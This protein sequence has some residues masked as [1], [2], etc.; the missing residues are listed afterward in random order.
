MANVNDKAAHAAPLARESAAGRT[1]CA[2]ALGD[3]QAT[4][5]QASTAA[6]GLLRPPT[7]PQIE[8]TGHCHATT[9]AA[10]GTTPARPSSVLDRILARQSFAQVRRPIAVSI[11]V[12]LCLVVCCAGRC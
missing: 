9:P 10:A 4:T 8:T 3:V 5:L 11:A 6:A 7:A 2:A 1:H 12:S